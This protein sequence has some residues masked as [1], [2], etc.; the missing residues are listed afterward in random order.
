MGTLLQDLKHGLRTLRKNPA[1]TGVAVL[2]LALGIG[3]ST[4][5][6]SAVN[7][8]LFESLPYP[9]AGRIMTIWDIFQGARSDVTFHTYRE[10]A[11]RN[12]SFDSI[13]VM[14]SWQPT[15]TGAAEPERFDGQSVSA[16]YFRVLG[17]EPVLGRDFQASDN[18][19]RGPKVTILSDGLWRRRFLAD[20]RIV[21]RQI[22]LDDDLYMV[23]GVM[24]RGF[25]NVLAPSA[26]LWSPTQYDPAHI[27]DLNTSEWGHHLRMVARLRPGVSMEQAR[28]DLQAIADH[29]VAQF[30]RAAW[31]ALKFGFIVDT[32]QQD[33]TRG[34]K[35][36]L[37]AVLGA[38]MLVLLIACVNATNLLLA[39]AAERRG[40]C[41]G[42]CWPKACCF[43]F[44][45][46]LSGCLW[47]N[48][49]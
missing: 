45:A 22:K 4:A 29:P 11:E 27:T 8:I 40:D 12:H 37:V 15:M 21:G 28:R 14:E 33:V 9:H 16:D 49:A 10:V 3:A 31:A 19:F 38:V 34:I 24:P 35:P 17:V 41:S 42:N 32:L 13:A 6:F 30:P 7:P 26:E 23:I 46:A 47:R 44:S 48:T 20:P 5:I 18:R 1:F 36:A 43:R 25:E 39:R 2:T